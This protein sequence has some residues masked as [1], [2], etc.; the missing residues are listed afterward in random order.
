ME[1]ATV[2]MIESFSNLDS[3][4]CGSAS[5]AKRTVSHVPKMFIYRLTRLLVLLDIGDLLFA[6]LNYG[7]VNKMS[8]SELTKESSGIVL[9]V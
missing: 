3:R 8:E 2:G 7:V 6:C 5:D 9:A 4:R 1:C